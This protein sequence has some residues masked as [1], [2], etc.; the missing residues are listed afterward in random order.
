MGAAVSLTPLPVSSM[1]ID[2]LCAYAALRRRPLVELTE[3]ELFRLNGVLICLQAE[4][5]GDA[6][7]T[8]RV[9]DELRRRAAQA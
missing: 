9:R 3:D 6:M 1:A 5:F 8:Y 7:V 2:A 4:G